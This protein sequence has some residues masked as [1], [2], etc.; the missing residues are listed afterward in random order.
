[1]GFARKLKRKGKNKMR[2]CGQ[3]MTYKDGY[4]YVCEICGK[5]K[6]VSFNA[7]REMQNMQFDCNN[8]K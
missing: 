6:E 5:M 1:M 8:N 7:D 4:G 2:C 3:Q